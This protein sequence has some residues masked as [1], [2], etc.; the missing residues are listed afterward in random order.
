MNDLELIAELKRLATCIRRG[1]PLPVNA[2]AILMVSAARMKALHLIVDE[3]QLETRY[4]T[5]T[6]DNEDDQETRPSQR[7]G[8]LP[9]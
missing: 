7:P 6:L 3:H 5:N 1:E 4:L 8:I 9:K 2:S